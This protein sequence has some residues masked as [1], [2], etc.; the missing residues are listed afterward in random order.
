MSM[1]RVGTALAEWLEIPSEQVDTE[2]LLPH[3]APPRAGARQ[4]GN[5]S[6]PARQG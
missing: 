2:R 6:F 3:K 5:R 4:L 1:G